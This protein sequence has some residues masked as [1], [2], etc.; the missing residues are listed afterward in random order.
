MMLL[1][2]GRSN[3]DVNLVNNTHQAQFS[4]ITSAAQITANRGNKIENG[5]NTLS[6]STPASPT[7]ASTK[8]AQ[9][10]NSDTANISAISTTAS[11]AQPY[12][13]QTPCSSIFTTTE[14]VLLSNSPGSQSES[15][16]ITVGKYSNGS[17][18]TFLANGNISSSTGALTTMTSVSSEN[19]KDIDRHLEAVQTKLKDGWSAHLGK[20]GRLYYCK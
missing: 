20:E 13:S 5:G 19:W 4:T 3:N 17:K 9:Y 16:T 6:T 15:G 8:S 1:P 7:M 12:G 10:T 2:S 18:V 14:N 11:N